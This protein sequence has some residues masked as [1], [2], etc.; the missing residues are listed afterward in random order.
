MNRPLSG[1]PIKK[2]T[3]RKVRRC[4]DGTTAFDLNTDDQKSSA[5]PVTGRSTMP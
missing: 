3:Y 2:Q 5:M 1:A 4:A